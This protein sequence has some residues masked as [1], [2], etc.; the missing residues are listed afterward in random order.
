M[1][2]SVRNLPAARTLVTLKRR[3][4]TILV[5]GI[6]T[7]AAGFMF[8]CNVVA[9]NVVSWPVIGLIL[10]VTG[11]LQ[12]VIAWQFRERMQLPAWGMVATFYLFFGLF[13]LT[14]PPPQ[15]AILA[16]FFFACVIATGAMRCYCGYIFLDM[17]GCHWLI[18]GG[19]PAIG[20]GGFLALQ[21]PHGDLELAGLLMALDLG[22]YGVSLIG[23]S[24]LLGDFT[25]E[26]ERE[27]PR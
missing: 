6:M 8:S 18:A 3:Q 7:A 17:R 10:C 4:A 14:S 12:L 11:L 16:L 24:L 1:S 25:G 22:L 5:M 15:L 9:L 26:A 27:P 21:W 20:I 23:F 19:A 13:A 2:F